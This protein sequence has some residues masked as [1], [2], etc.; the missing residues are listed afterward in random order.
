M[1][2][3]YLRSAL[4]VALWS[5]SQAHAADLSTI[6]V[7]ASRQAQ[8][9]PDVL[10]D[11]NILTREYLDKAGQSTLSEVLARQPGLQM[12]ANGGP[13][14]QTGIF[15]R[16]AEARHTLVLVDGLRI[17]S[18]TTG[19]S[20]LENIPLADIERVEILR[21]PASSLYGA[22]AL[23]G[24]IQIFTRRGEGA[25]RFDAFAAKGSFNTQQAEAG[26]RGS[27]NALS[28]SLRI[29]TY[30][31]D[32]I[33]SASNAAKLPLSYNRDR[34]GFSQRHFSGS[35]NYRLEGRDEIGLSLLK[36]D[37]VNQY[38]A[39]S[40]NF[41]DRID[42]TTASYQL[43]LRNH[44]GK[45][46]TSLMRLGRSLDEGNAIN[47]TNTSRFRTVQKH[48]HWQNDVMLPLGIALLAYEHNEQKVSSTTI[49]LVN[50]RNIDS[51]LLGWSAN[52]G[53][54]RLQL[55]SRHDRNSQFGRQ[56]TGQIGYGYQLSTAWRIKTAVGTA[57]NAPTFNQL[58]WPHDRFGGGN[59]RLQ[60]EMARNAEVGLDWE[61]EGQKL[62]LTLFRNRVQNLISG[63]PPAN[64]NRAK[65]DG[66]TLAYAVSFISWQLNASL[67]LLEARDEATHKRLP[68]RAEQQLQLSLGRDVGLW[69]LGAEWSDVGR[70][71]DDT[72]NRRP[73]AGYSVL[74]AYARYRLGPEL[75]LEL[76]ANN[77]TDRKYETAYGYGTPG[78]NLFVGL[79][80]A[81]R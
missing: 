16:G 8:H 77:I 74:N 29:G 38:D 51:Y 78:V 45:D 13:G 2:R 33:S 64:V 70:R 37:G 57:F 6:V 22:D 72:V 19:Q 26:L 10:G 1:H 76:R 11:V 5:A 36:A 23:G 20:A 49:Y 54:H 35:L 7:T 9:A 39:G 75:S 59:P 48:F 47:A 28:Y 15:I 40:G 68:R 18:A 62:G 79:R 24:V 34:D 12:S 4:A 44:L 55:N 32:G 50:E 41:N 43:F 73:M 66:A 25:P 52:L 17:N 27:L 65:L 61:Q 67:D 21:G 42:K 14:A 53:S 31:T 3:S 60:P 81:M 69:H 46:W 80:Y 63:W 71:Y 30:D 58:Y 56:T